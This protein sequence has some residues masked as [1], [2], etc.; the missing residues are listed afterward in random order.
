MDNFNVYSDIKARTNG[1]IYVG[2]VGPVR[3]GKSTFIK[4]FMELMVLPGM[5]DRMQGSAQGMN[6]PK[7]PPGKP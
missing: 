5:D 3:T 2:I 6:C 1:E 4:R 7:A